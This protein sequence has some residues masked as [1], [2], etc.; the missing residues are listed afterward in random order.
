MTVTNHW[1]VWVDSEVPIVGVANSSDIDWD[2][3]EERCLTCE[4]IIEE[5]D[6][7]ATEA[8]EELEC[9]DIE[10]D[11]SHTKILG[12]WRE[13]ADGKLEPDPEGE[14]AIVVGEIYAQVLF[15]KTTKR[16]A[17][18]SPCYPGQGDLDTPGEF[19]TY[20]LPEGVCR[21]AE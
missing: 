18:C 20:A 6:R 9:L 7:E 13:A 21:E 4:A 11:G 15:S 14:Y 12:D 2:F 8:G 1:G 17:L 3:L 5:A 19:L 16:C 10:C